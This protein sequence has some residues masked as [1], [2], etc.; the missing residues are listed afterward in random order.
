MDLIEKASRN[1]TERLAWRLARKDQAG[2]AKELADGKDISEACP[3]AGPAPGKSADEVSESANSDRRTPIR[4]PVCAESIATYIQAISARTLEKLFNDA[5]F[6]SWKVSWRS[7]I[8]LLS[9][10]E[11][12]SI[13]MLRYCSSNSG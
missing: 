7:V 13:P 12:I 10:P 8:I 11:E 3:S 1:I 2:I 9:W 6:S 4:G 5:S